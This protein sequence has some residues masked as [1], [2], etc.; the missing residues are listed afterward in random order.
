MAL[1]ELHGIVKRY[2]KE[3]V[4]QSIDLVV[5]PGSLTVIVGP[6]GCGKTT[7]LRLIAGLENL[8]GGEIHID[9]RRIDPLPP[10]DRNVAMVFQN[11]ALYPHMTV[12]EN[13][14]FPLRIQGLGHMDIQRRVTETAAMLGLESVLERKPGYLSGGQQQRVALGRAMV[15]KPALF[16]FDEPLS[17]L[18]AKLRE[19]LRQELSALHTRLN[20]TMIYVTHD[21]A[22]AM[23][24]ADH[25]VVM[26]HG[27]VQQAAPPAEVY[28]AP[29][30]R[31]VAEFVGSP[32]MSLLP[33]RLV[34]AQVG[35]AVW[36]GNVSSSLSW[37]AENTEI[38][39]ILVGIRPEDICLQSTACVTIE[40][41]YFEV[42]VE[43]MHS[44]GHQVVAELK[45]TDGCR[46]TALAER[47]KWQWRAGDRIN[48][49]VAV[50][51]LHIFD[52]YTGL[53][54]TK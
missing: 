33:G 50:A 26:E 37:K 9:G 6:S 15:R 54:I 29:A 32:S 11:Y 14:G 16:L 46:M 10:R 4:L 24:L 53:R 25:L 30:N 1:V 21:Q 20:A 44:S 52:L 43:R 7:L 19:E 36:V 28:E 47:K 8:T 17:N 27:A 12:R 48:A 3:T 40:G 49:V 39:N 35:T 13:I 23:T 42:V 45:T 5:E 31:F 38:Q 41:L 2:G 22:E 34:R 51:D 18:D